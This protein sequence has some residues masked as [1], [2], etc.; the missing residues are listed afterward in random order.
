[1][2]DGPLVLVGRIGRPHG[3][4]GEMKAYATGATLPGIR[5]GERVA[6]GDDECPMRVDALR[7]AGRALLMRLEGVSD[8]AAAAALTGA[9]L[10]VEQTRLAPLGA[11]DEFYVRDLIGCEVRVGQG[12]LGTV[13]D[14]HEGFANDALV[15]RRDG[16]GDLLIPFTHDAVLGVDLPGRRVDVRDGLLPADEAP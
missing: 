3:V 12:V 7:S 10:R 15:V 5:P 8:R 14:V 16:R 2:G 11:P 9:A 6:V 1:M 4:T 13:A